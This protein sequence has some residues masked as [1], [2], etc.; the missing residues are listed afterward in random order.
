M[1]VQTKIYRLDV[2]SRLVHQSRIVSLGAGG[3]GLKRQEQKESALVR[4][5][6]WGLLKWTLQSRQA[7]P[8]PT[9]THTHNEICE[10]ETEKPQN[11][12]VT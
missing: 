10:P 9:H 11:T 3:G 1:G 2:H 4:E 5:L 8:T 6:A 12:I 7:P